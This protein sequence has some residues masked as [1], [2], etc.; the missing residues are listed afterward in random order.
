MELFDPLRIGPLEVGGRVFKAATTET[1]GTVDGF[2]TDELL[3]FYEPMARA[4]TPLIVTG[5]LYV[6]VQGKAFY[7][8]CGIDSDDKVPGLRRL[9]ELAHG[10]GSAVFAQLGHCGRQMFPKEMEIPE[11]VAPS[12]VREPITWTKPRAMTRE[13]IRATV[14]DFGDAAARAREAG[15]DGVQLMAAVGYLISEFLTP[16][17]NRR[18]DE[19]GGSLRNRMR[20]ALEVLAA[21]HERAGGDFPVSFRLNGSDKLPLRRGL[22]TPELVEVAR[23]LEAE[24]ADAIEITAGHYESGIGNARGRFDGFFRTSLREG[25]F[26]RG[27]PA[28]RRGLGL[29]G[30]PV[31]E[32]LA[33]VVW[34][35]RE[36]FL[37]PYSR[38]FTEALEIPVVC[39]G[40]F[41]TREGMEEAVRAGHCDA[42]S[43]ARG[44]IADPML[45][46]HLRDGVQGPDCT[47][48][49][50][51]LARVGYLPAD[52]YEPRVRAERDT[53]LSREPVA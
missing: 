3:A 24:G 42:V 26:A 36:G 40:G 11:A 39:V 5:M 32:R 7:R 17:T 46:A 1:R 45:W 20:F 50:R 44:M 21:V 27:T 14:A 2:V 34:S 9:T 19:Y 41:H 49:N 35:T 12:A 37:L 43:V 4:G 53:M 8:S 51:C 38:Q 23:G 25:R 6:N 13:E 10:G 29:L 15:F 31:V 33:N 47:F 18:T 22:D 30:A 48:C 16:H 28:V 52:C